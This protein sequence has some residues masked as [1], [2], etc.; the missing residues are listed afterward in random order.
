MGDEIHEARLA[1]GLSQARVALAAGVPQTRL[2]RI[3]RH[4]QPSA[5]LRDLACILTVLGLELSARAYPGGTPIRDAAQRALLDRLRARSASTLRWRFEVPIPIPGDQRAW[6]ATI[7][8]SGGTRVA[9]EAE[10]RLRDLQAL[11][12][13][14]AL[15]FRDDPSVTAVVLLVSETRANRRVIRDQPTALAADF[16]EG[17]RS[18]LGALAEGQLPKGSGLVLM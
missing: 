1:L 5:S 10:T 17:A 16:P 13:R 9:V 12:R 4:M 8:E 7:E 3:E 18:I 11:Q 15:K 14:V 6:D 2:S